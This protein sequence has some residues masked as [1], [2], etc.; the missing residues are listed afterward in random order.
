M[1]PTVPFLAA[2]E[3]LC[4]CRPLQDRRTDSVEASILRRVGER[5]C[6]TMSLLC[7]C[8][9][10]LWNHTSNLS[11]AMSPPTK[12]AYYCTVSFDCMSAS[13]YEL[14]PTVST[15][16]CFRLCHVQVQYL[17]RSAA[18]SLAL[19]YLCLWLAMFAGRPLDR[20]AG[21]A[22]KTRLYELAPTTDFMCSH[23]SMVGSGTYT[24]IHNV[25]STMVDRLCHN[26]YV[27]WRAGKAKCA[28]L[29]LQRRK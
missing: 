26:P 27:A 25:A 29:Q 9:N 6:K 8:H 3:I 21:V 16:L 23:V 1:R 15:R 12:F 10:C 11:R 19:L 17:P 24:K 22:S 2:C 18:H 14:H 13:R 7:S 4:H 5:L 28:N 20:I